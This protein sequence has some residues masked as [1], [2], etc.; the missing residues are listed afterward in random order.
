MENLVSS[1]PS[2]QTAAEYEAA[3][4]QLL[5]EIRRLNEQ[6]QDDR[7]DIERLRIETQMLKVETRAVLARIG[8]AL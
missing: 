6:M 7:L 8:A 5:A 1:P 3:V 2:L 4:E